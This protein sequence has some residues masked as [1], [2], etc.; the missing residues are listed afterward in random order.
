MLKIGLQR[1]KLV[2]IMKAYEDLLSRNKIEMH[3]LRKASKERDNKHRIELNIL[4]NTLK[5]IT[6]A[7]K[8]CQTKLHK[9]IGESHDLCEKQGLLKIKLDDAEQKI[10][11]LFDNIIFILF[12]IS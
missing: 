7:F 10:F 6:Q 4:K 8:V 11:R 9:S 12:Y 5:E 1:D 2:S 3:R